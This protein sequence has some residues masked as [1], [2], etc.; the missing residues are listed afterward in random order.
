VVEVLRTSP[1][2]TV[3]VPALADAVASLSDDAAEDVAVLLSHSDLPKL[4]AARI[5]AYDD[6]ARV[7]EYDS[8]PLVERC[9]DV[10]ETYRSENGGHCPTES[11]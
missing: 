5:I 3:E 4:A 8:D 2:G 6:E 9:L 10:A 11:S 7:V 1:G